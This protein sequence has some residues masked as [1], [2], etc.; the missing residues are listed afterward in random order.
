MKYEIR[1]FIFENRQA[2]T[3]SLLAVDT[4]IFKRLDKGYLI[5]LTKGD[6]DFKKI[7]L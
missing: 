1:H 4:I 3:Q 6:Y 7:L 5:C 2:V